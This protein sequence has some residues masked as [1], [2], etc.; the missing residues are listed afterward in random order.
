MRDRYEKEF[1]PDGD[2]YGGY[3]V[4][5][6]PCAA[7]PAVIAPDEDGELMAVANPAKIE[8]FQRRI[9]AQRALHHPGDKGYRGRR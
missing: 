3:Q 4:D 9:A 6:Q 2:F 1:D 8:V 5:D 7:P